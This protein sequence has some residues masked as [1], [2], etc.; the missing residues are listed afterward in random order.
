MNILFL[1]RKKNL[2]NLN[3]TDIKKYGEEENLYVYDFLLDRAFK[4][5]CEKNQNNANKKKFTLKEPIVYNKQKNKTK[6]LNFV[7]IYN[8]IDRPPDHLIKF[9]MIS[10]DCRKIFIDNNSKEL[11]IN[12][13][14]DYEIIKK[15]IL[16]YVKNY[17]K[18]N[19]CQKFE[20]KL[21][22]ENRLLY[23]KCLFCHAKRC[24][25]DES[26]DYIL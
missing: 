9:F 12:R 25:N 17:V 6:I 20:T 11:I 19:S 7:E 16:R 1:M 18:C 8:N 10:L 3:N 24:C 23:V 21:I 2:E 13:N 15:A 26:N 22:K 5:M 14:V 4:V